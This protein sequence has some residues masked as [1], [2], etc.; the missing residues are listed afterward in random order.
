MNVGVVQVDGNLP[1]LA[2]MKIAAYHASKGDCVE[3]WL[4][5]LFNYDKVYA[6]KIFKFSEMPLLPDN[7]EIGGTGIDWENRLPD[8]IDGQNPGDA[9]CLYPKFNKHLGFSELGCRFKC[10]FCCVPQKEG[11]PREASNIKS[12]L[13][14]PNGE[15]R[16]VLLDDD[17]FGQPL[18]EDKCKEI[19]SL[20][21]KVCFSQ[22]LNIRVITEK[23]ARYLAQIK[24]KN[25]NFTGRQVTFAWDQFK[26]KKLIEKGFRRCV[27]AGIKPYQMQFFVLIGY[28]TTPE[29]DMERVTL[30]KDW[31]CDPFVM[32]YN[33][34]D[35]YQRRFQRWVNH[36]AIFKTVRF[37]EYS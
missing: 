25:I 12:L 35:L 19:I 31:G 23:Q 3:W 22:G 14:N 33:R 2:I 13:D 4:G 34:D 24:F 17:F 26:D 6:S 10:S 1:N 11:K 37:S 32:A 20:N 21:L 18:W 29:Q 15:D 36:R 27:D 30:L 16:L 7:A 8:E 9:W 28:D 5:P